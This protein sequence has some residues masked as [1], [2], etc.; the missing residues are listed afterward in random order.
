MKL[1]KLLEAKFAKKKIIAYHGTSGKNLRSIIKNGLLK[2]FRDGGYGSDETDDDFGIDFSPHEGVYLT[3]RILDA[4]TIADYVDPHHPVI[5]T[6]EVQ[7]KSAYLDEDEI[8]L[9]L[10]GITQLIKDNVGRED[11][12]LED[13][14]KL[15]EI[16][17]RIQEKSLQH[18]NNTLKN[19]Y[20]L[21]QTTIDNIIRRIKPHLWKFIY[22]LINAYLE[23]SY[24]DVRD[25]QDVMRKAFKHVVRYK[26]ENHP[27]LTRFSV[28]YN[29]GFRGAN[30]IIGIADYKT[31]K[32]WGAVRVNPKKFKMVSTPA[33][34]IS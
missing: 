31:K 34:L 23:G 9:L 7:P 4:R 21:S 10:G 30:R 11:I 1:N 26:L 14:D 24:A 17:N 16:E 25:A 12:S 27:N 3:S 19:Y 6:V 15:S 20:R 32:A 28:P 2:N 13:E 18:L 22:E 33:E 8:N 29:I 5:I